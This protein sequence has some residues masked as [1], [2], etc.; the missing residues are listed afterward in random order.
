[1]LD[2]SILCHHVVL[3]PKSTGL[4]SSSKAA[5]HALAETLTVELSPFNIRVLLV[6]PGAF[7][8][9]GI[10]GQKYH[11]EKPISAYDQMR[12][13]SQKMFQAVPG[14]QKGDPDKAME[15]VVDVV[16]GEGIAKER[17]WPGFLVL[18]EDAERELVAKCNKVLQ[19]VEEWGDVSRS[20]LFDC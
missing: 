17:P 8:T 9:E 10:Y 14:T 3:S 16:R 7:R 1:M 15:V 18:G 4:Y 20:V 6:A 2:A 5:V 19:L 13:A 12:D 11:V